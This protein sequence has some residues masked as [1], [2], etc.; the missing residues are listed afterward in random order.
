MDNTFWSYLTAMDTLL[1]KLSRD[2]ERYAETLAY[3][4]RLRENIDR[5][6]RYGDSETL[7]HER[8]VLLAEINALSLDVIGASFNQMITDAAAERGQSTLVEARQLLSEGSYGGARSR[9]E[10]A[11]ECLGQDVSPMIRQRVE[12]IAKTNVGWN[13]KAYRELQQRLDEVIPLQMT[14]SDHIYFMCARGLLEATRRAG[15][16]G[17]KASYEA[18]GQLKKAYDLAKQLLELNPSAEYLIRDCARL[19]RALIDL[20]TQRAQKR[21]SLAQAALAERDY[22]RA[23]SLLNEALALEHLDEEMRMRLVSEL[24]SLQSRGT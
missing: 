18:M 17:A 20:Q 23:E 11:L 10:V 21:L 4:Q 3:Q 6:R 14:S 16:A 1:S 9:F 2:H 19:L 5:T 24:N 15:I 22:L 13:D 8:S 12:A 7:R